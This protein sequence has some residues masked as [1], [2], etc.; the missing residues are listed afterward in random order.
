MGTL[1]RLMT[2]FGG[3]LRFFG[4]CLFVIPVAGAGLVGCGGRDPVDQVRLV[5]VE[6]PVIRA[7]T[8]LSLSAQ[9]LPSGRTLEVTLQGTL[10]AAGQD[11][12]T[13]DVSLV[14]HVLSPER[15][16][17][18][19]DPARFARW[20]RATFEGE[21]VVRCDPP[22]PRG[23]H[24]S[25]SGVRFDVELLGQRQ[26]HALRYRVDRL[27]PSLGVGI[28]DAASAAHGLL[29]AE[30]SDGSLAARAGLLPGDTI[31][32]SNGVTLHAL[33]DM[34]P[35]PKA[36]TLALWVRRASGEELAVR[37]A[38][39]EAAPWADPRVLGLCLVACPVLLFL[40]LRSGWVTPAQLLP[41]AFARVS[42]LRGSMGWWFEL[43]AVLS[44]VFGALSVLWA[45]AL[46]PFVL[47]LAHLAGLLALRGL[48]TRRLGRLVIDV[49][50]LWGGVLAVAAVSGTR[51][52]S[53][54]VRDQGVA[55]WA[56]NA[57]SRLPLSLALLVYLTGAAGLH[58]AA[59]GSEVTRQPAMLPGERA[60][61]ALAA[62]L[63]AGLFLGGAH[64]PASAGGLALTLGAAAAACKSLSCYVLFGAVN[65]RGLELARVGSWIA[66]CAVSM[67]WAHVAP[68]RAFELSWGS[69]ACMLF[70]LVALTALLSVRAATGP[71]ADKPARKGRAR[72]SSGGTSK[73]TGRA[74]G[75]SAVTADTT[76]T[77]AKPKTAGRV[78][79]ARGLAQGRT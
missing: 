8:P 39:A 28:S 51:D 77:K 59:A 13:L 6:S 34:V 44:L 71:R 24:G 45:S 36:E 15:L 61:A 53:L 40:L 19:I 22:T 73:A 69:A 76:R 4:M 27:L 33:A 11:E 64:L 20:G 60:L 2:D 26:A 23:C 7:D 47:L 32:R 31:V 42:A 74:A 17:V 1:G 50:G 70:G 57:F 3:W 12:R 21:V 65:R 5:G 55:P 72:A 54:L 37:V 79:P 30:V 41:S 58:G 52:W 25:L 62:T 46:D 9:G 16:S 66:L 67:V 10:A 29:V 48:D 38:L 75:R 14:G 68:S 78:R 56:W 43:G 35:G 63:C 18:A 49:L